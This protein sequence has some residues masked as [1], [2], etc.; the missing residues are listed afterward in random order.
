MRKWFAAVLLTLISALY[1]S[2]APASAHSTVSGIYPAPDSRLAK[3]PEQVELTFNE[4]LE[5]KLYTIGVY[6][7]KGMPVTKRQAEMDD[8]RRT[9][10]LPLPAL[11]EGSYTVTYR[12]LSADGHPVRASYVFTVG[13]DTAPRMGYTSVSKLHEEHDISQNAGYWAV[14]LFYYTAL[15]STAGWVGI[16]L[17]ASGLA[18]INR[19]RYR[20]TLR[21]LLA[22]YIAALATMG[23]RDFARL[24]EGFGS[25]NQP[26]V[27][28][29][30]SIGISYLLSFLAAAAGF[31]ALG[32]R[33]WLDAAWIVLFLGAKS[34]NGHAM[35]YAVPAVTALL[36][37]IHMAAASVWA[38]VLFVFALFGWKR[39]REEVAPYLPH[40]SKAALWAIVILVSSGV[41]NALLYSNGFSHLVETWWGKLLLAKAAAVLLVIGTG[42]MLRRTIKNR[43]YPQLTGW[44]TLD[45]ALFAV[46]L[47]ITAV[48]TYLNPLAATG[49]LFWHENVKGVHIAAIVT[50]NKPGAV[51][52]FNVSLGTGS[53]DKD[54]KKVTLRLAY[55]DNPDIAPIEVPLQQVGTNGSPLSL[56]NY[57]YSAEGAYLPFSGKWEL[58]IRVRDENDDELLTSKTFY[59]ESK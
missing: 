26:A 40:C 38:G 15:L 9:I 56:Y 48:F 41:I 7:G 31:L 28:L 49:P 37:V 46:I 27:V 16:R 18:E 34:L 13:L 20:L 35:G 12:I 11:A 5:N 21:L 51:N 47:C 54:L 32:R 17:Y 55:T 19:R 36:D 29:G 4:R 22:V 24:G 25:M 14:R 44:L 23:W 6:N 58:E 59:S 50:P 57:N 43:H 30:T 52:Q 3:P 42:A 8:K 2:A 1:L 10:R 39:R 33:K 53:G 45:L